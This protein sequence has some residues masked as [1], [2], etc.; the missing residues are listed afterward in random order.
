V[1]TKFAGP[2][3]TVPVTSGSDRR[4]SGGPS[5]DG[6]Y[7]IQFEWRGSDRTA[8]VVASEGETILEAGEG[9]ELGLPFGCR[10]GV[11]ATCVARL[12]EGKVEHRRETRALKSRHRDSGYIL[13]CVAVPSSDLRLEV[14]ARIQADLVTG[15][16]G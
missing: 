16:R 11:C 8:T 10:R 7:R 1:R 13:P 5:A 4:A 15:P 2:T 12:L 3:G 6:G 14:G 9:A